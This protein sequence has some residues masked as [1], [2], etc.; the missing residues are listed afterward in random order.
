MFYACKAH[1][2]APGV[3]IMRRVRVHFR[4]RTKLL[5]C[6]ALC[7]SVE[8]QKLKPYCKR[9][10]GGCILYKKPTTSMSNGG[11]VGI[12]MWSSLGLQAYFQ[13]LQSYW[14]RLH[15]MVRIGLGA[16]RQSHT[17]TYLPALI[18][19]LRRGGLVMPLVDPFPPRNELVVGRAGA[20]GPVHK[21]PLTPLVEGAD[22]PPRREPAKRRAARAFR[23][24]REYMYYI[25]IYNI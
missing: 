22:E 23:L 16:Y 21:A 15:E 4:R 12:Y 14:R 9:L 1:T 11:W 19:V 10:V 8:S 17:H 6:E 18:V 13:E 5:S 7:Q 20:R 24:S 3:R 2:S 25:Y